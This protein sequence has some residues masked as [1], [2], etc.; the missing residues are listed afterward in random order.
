M[1]STGKTHA[2]GPELEDQRK[3]GGGIRERTGAQNHQS[4]IRF[5]HELAKLHELMGAQTQKPQVAADQLEQRQRDNFLQRPQEL[6]SVAGRADDHE[7]AEIDADF[8]QSPW[9]DFGIRRVHPSAP[10]SI[11]R[12]KCGGLGPEGRRAKTARAGKQ[13]QRTFR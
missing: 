12:Y 3:S 2:T 13:R 11:L 10:L 7:V 4:D 1:Q 8:T 5:L 9:A 6:F